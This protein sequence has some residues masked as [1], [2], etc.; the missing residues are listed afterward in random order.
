MPC[1]DVTSQK[2]KSNLEMYYF[3]VIVDAGLNLRSAS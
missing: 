3:A 1:S 2:R